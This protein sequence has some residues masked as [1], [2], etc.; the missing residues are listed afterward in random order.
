MLATRNSASG[1][2]VYAD[3][4]LINNALAQYP[5]AVADVR[6]ANPTVPVTTPALWLSDPTLRACWAY[7]VANDQLRVPDYN[8]KQ[9]GSINSVMFRGDGTLGFAPGRIRQD[10]IQNITGT[11]ISGTNIGMLRPPANGGSTTGAFKRGATAG[12]TTSAGEL[13]GSA[14]I[15]FDASGSARTGA[16]TFPTHAIIIWGVVLFGGVTN[17]GAAD[18]AALAASYA[19]QQ[20]QIGAL[21]AGKRNKFVKSPEQTVASGGFLVWAHGLGVT[22]ESIEA[23]YLCKTAEYGWV[24]G[25]IIRCSTRVFASTTEFGMQYA[26]D[27]TSV[28]IFMPDV[29]SILQK[30]I[31]GGGV[32]MTPARWAIIIK[33]ERP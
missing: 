26:A 24:P 31:R 33:V 13:A 8:G 4:Q 9:P 18:A 7:D 22:P 25:D 30:A 21:D 32:A 14:H 5:A 12:F 15:D 10:Q 20:T 16:E 6:S 11:A 29:L 19:N 2:V 1:G 23:Y 3:G 17:P 28:T 27:A